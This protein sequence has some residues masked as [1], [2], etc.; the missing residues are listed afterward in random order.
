MLDA[1]YIYYLTALI[2][3][4]PIRE[5]SNMIIFLIIVKKNIDQNTR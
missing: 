5:I 2:K 4:E 3:I 1:S